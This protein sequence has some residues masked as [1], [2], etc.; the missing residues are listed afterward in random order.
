MTKTKSH[1]AAAMRGDAR[2]RSTLRLLSVGWWLQLKMR[3]RSAFDGVLASLIPPSTVMPLATSAL[4]RAPV[5]NRAGS[6]T[7]YT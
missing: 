5:V 3:T 2:L 4:R 6:S 7:T 1:Q